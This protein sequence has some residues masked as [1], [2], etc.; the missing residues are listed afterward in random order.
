MQN[1]EAPARLIVIGTALFALLSGCGKSGGDYA[2]SVAWAINGMLPTPEICREQ[3]I[4]RGRLEVQDR[5]GENAQAL[6]GDCAA[7]VFVP[8]PDLDDPNF[9]EYGGFETS[10]AF[11][12]DVPYLY[13]VSLVDASGRPVARP[14][15]GEMVRY[16]GEGDFFDLP[17]IDYLQPSGSDAV[18][19][20]QWDFAGEPDVAKACEA[21]RI[22]T[23]QVLVSTILDLDGINE[24]AFQEVPCAAGAFDSKV[25]VLA[26]GAYV[27]RLEAL[28]DGV[29]ARISDPIAGDVDRTV[30]PAVVSVPRATFQ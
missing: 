4:A 22:D 27:F 19:K 7:T 2:A 1:M 11:E 28:S 20:V 13:T 26:T 3:G 29:R 23:V 15:T 10:E 17:K 18:L 6:E 8:G 12:Y 14:A 21:R 24:V 30:V 5:R 25:P 16:R 9:Y